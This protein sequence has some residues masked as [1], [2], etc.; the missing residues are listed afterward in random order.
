MLLTFTVHEEDVM[1]KSIASVALVAGALALESSPRAAVRLLIP[2]QDPG[3]PFYASIDR[4]PGGQIFQDGEWAA[5]PFLRDPDCVLSDSNLIV[6]FDLRAFRCPLT[7]HGFDIY[8][9]GPPPIDPVPVYA[10]LMGDGA[11]PIWF[12]RWSE[13]QAAIAEGQLYIWDLRSLPSLLIGSAS[14]FEF[15]NQIGILRPQG[16]G[17]GKIEVVSSGTLNDGREFQFSVR[18]MGV[19]QISTLRHVRIE[20]R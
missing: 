1:K 17:N 8:K 10:L 16:A 5:I 14:F 19:D 7:V 6:A 15:V 18:E 3:P 2:S 13:L 20:F 4:P 9:N 12:V 11:V